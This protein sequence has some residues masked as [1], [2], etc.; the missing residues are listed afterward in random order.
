[1]ENENKH[2]L[3]DLRLQYKKLLEADELENLELEM[4]KPNIFNIL[5]ISRMEIRHSNF[6]RWLLDPKESHGLGN[7]FLVRI[8]RDLAL[9]NNNDLDIIN[10]SSLNFNNADVYREY[11][12]SSIKD[13]NKKGFIDILIDFKTEKDKETEKDKDKLVICIE[14]KIDTTDFEEQL[15][16]YNEH[17]KKTFEGYKHVFVY[18]TP[19]GAEPN[20]KNETESWSNYSYEE[21]IRHLGDIQKSIPDSTIKTYISDY[22]TTLKNEIMGTLSEAQAL[23]NAI[24]ENHQLIIDFVNSNRDVNKKHQEYWERDDNK[25]FLEFAKKLK[26]ILDN[27]NKSTEYKLGYTQDAIT[28]TQ[29]IKNR[30]YKI[31]SVYPR[32]TD[33]KSINIEFS[34]PSKTKE[35]EK[36]SKEK[37]KE[38]VEEKKE[39]QSIVNCTDYT[40]GFR[41]FSIEQF[42]YKELQEIHNARVGLNQSL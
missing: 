28:I 31:Y 30:F 20:D 39:K 3:D 12:I 5:G 17:I 9:D 37:V 33:K 16:T 23:A 2:D 40:S 36:D 26:K 15:S 6:L 35:I 24:Y 18:L 21:I 14:N 29:W 11:P 38:I 42:D 27:T 10:V 19:Y 13:K 4:Q 34:F 25:N 22:L 1:M 41:I 7:K 32:T 8:L